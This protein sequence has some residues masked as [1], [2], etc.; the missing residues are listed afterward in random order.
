MSGIAKQSNTE[1][2]QLAFTAE[3]THNKGSASK[4]YGTEDSLEEREKSSASRIQIRAEKPFRSDQ[5]GW[6]VGPQQ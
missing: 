5:R 1:A 4:K 6:F 3:E 2:R